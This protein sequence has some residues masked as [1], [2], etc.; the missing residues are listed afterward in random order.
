MWVPFFMKNYERDLRGSPKLGKLGVFWD[1]I[2][3]NGYL[4]FSEKILDMGTY[5]YFWEIYLGTMAC[6]TNSNPNKS[7]DPPLG[8]WVHILHRRTPFA[9]MNILCTSRDDVPVITH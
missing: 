8:P 9:F 1:K 5:M 6:L 2:T 3:R 4:P 7:D